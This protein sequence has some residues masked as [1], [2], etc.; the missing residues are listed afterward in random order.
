MMKFTK[1]GCGADLSARK[2]EAGKWEIGI[3]AVILGVCVHTYWLRPVELLLE[4]GVPNR[5]IPDVIE[6]TIAKIA[7]DKYKPSIA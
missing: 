5:Y 2:N 1:Y 4:A 7:L 3:G 6:D